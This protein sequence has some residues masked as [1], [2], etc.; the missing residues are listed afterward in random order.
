MGGRSKGKSH[1]KRRSAPA[2]EEMLV[3]KGASV[4]AIRTWDDAEKD[5]DDEFDAV[6]DKVLLGYDK[7]Q[8][9][10]GNA[11]DFES[12]QEVLGVDIANDSSDAGSGN[13]DADD[14]EFY[15]DENDESGKSGKGKQLEDGAWGKQKHNYYDADDIGTD[16]DDD[17]AA[18]KEEEEEALR[19]QKQQLEALDEEDFMDEFS[20]QL[21]MS[22]SDGASGS[23]SRLVSSVDD[24]QAQIDLEK[25]SLDVDG[26]FDISDA[27]RQALANLPEKEK[28]KV[29]AAESPEL[30]SLADDMQSYWASVRSDMRP[31][32]E[33]AALLGVSADDH[34][35][36]A[37]YTVKYQLSMSY[38]NNIA[39]YLVLKA[40]TAGERGGVE[41]RDHP[42]I[43][44]IVEFRRR[45]EMMDG[46]QTKLAP[47]LDLFAEELESGSIGADIKP[48]ATADDN[49]TASD[50]DVEMAVADEHDEVP[51]VPKSKKQSR[52]KKSKDKAEP[53][54]ESVVPATTN[55]YAE[56]Q[57]ML[58]KEKRRKKSSDAPAISS[59]EALADGDFG[60][61]E[62]LDEGDA[63][64]KERAIRRL[65]NHAKRIAQARSK[66][67]AKVKLTGDMD[68]PYK[69]RKAERLRFD[70]KTAESVRKQAGKYGDDLDMGMD[71]DSDIGEAGEAGGDDDDD[72]YKEVAQ[73]AA[74]KKSQA[75][76]EKKARKEAQ[77]K[78]IVEANV[79][80]DANVASDAKR[81][82][83]YQILKNKGLM[84]RRTKEQRNPR[85]KRKVRY[86]KAKKKL[87]STAVQVRKLEGNYGGEATGIKANLTRST[88]FA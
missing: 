79:A 84:P 33:K 25:V 48:A 10:R 54:L 70:S 65:R 23:F 87:S 34:P 15:S 1:S 21:G 7:R 8:G 29:I 12:D 37:F 43:G 45:L 38:L 55:S 75:K 28:L 52:S 69:D 5:S 36:L 62:R 53:F 11:S 64:D 32:L 88:R 35:A 74:A 66:R 31:I 85:V 44:S 3:R 20:A 4:K 27:K 26:A 51:E 56:L 76:A 86:E 78:M 18:A 47:L 13:E 67:D 9:R 17:E 61:Q 24:S 77:W 83:S 30:L 68:V 81:S 71:L 58:K 19:L 49:L 14:A 42:V 41:L 63:E 39:V 80:E 46:L 72:Y 57:R 59:W 16:T 2:D 40:S 60:E 82:V 6:R 50:S 22:T 73:H